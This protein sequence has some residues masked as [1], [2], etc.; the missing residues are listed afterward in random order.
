[1]EKV[2]QNLL[3]AHVN[4][5][6]DYEKKLGEIQKERQAVFQDAFQNDLKD[7]KTLGKIPSKTTEY[8]FKILFPFV[9]SNSVITDV[10]SNIS[11]VHSLAKLLGVLN[12]NR[13]RG[14]L[15]YV[16]R[17]LNAYCILTEYF[18]PLKCYD[19]HHESTNNL[20]KPTGGLKKH[21]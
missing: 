21:P 19:P 7:Y 9:M 13:K 14:A 1:M 5:V 11:D 18:S 17:S 4:N 16:C 15:V 3:D 12:L 2:R 6:H 8:K 20:T 10:T